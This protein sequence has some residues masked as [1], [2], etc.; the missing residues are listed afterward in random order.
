MNHARKFARTT[1]ADSV[2]DIFTSVGNNLP[3]PW[4]RALEVLQIMYKLDQGSVTGGITPEERALIDAFYMDFV[5]LVDVPV[6]LMTAHIKAVNGNY[7]GAIRDYIATQSKYPGR[8][9]VQ[10][11][12]ASAYRRM[13]DTEAAL[14][15]LNPLLK[16]QPNHPDVLYEL[17][18][19]QKMTGSPDVGA[20]AARLAEIWSGADEIFIPAREIRAA[21]KD[22]P[23][24]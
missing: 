20:T 10:K 8:I 11:D 13:G 9:L 15:T 17:Y 18:Q 19:I 2:L 6:E 24:I 21:L 7:E 12:I 22:I 1:M 16:V 3:D 4:N 23:E 5:F 14:A